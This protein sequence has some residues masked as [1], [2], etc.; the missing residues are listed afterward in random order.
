[1]RTAVFIGTNRGPVQIVRFVA[2]SGLRTGSMMVGPDGY[3]TAVQRTSDFAHFLNDMCRWGLEKCGKAPLPPHMLVMLDHDIDVGDSWQLGIM[4]AAILHAEGLFEPDLDAAEQVVLCTGSLKGQA[5]FIGRVSLIPEKLRSSAGLISELRARR[6]PPRCVWLIPRA[7]RQELLADE[8]RSPVATSCDASLHPIVHLIESVAEV[9]AALSLPALG[10]S[11]APPRGPPAGIGRRRSGWVLAAI[12]MAML[13]ALVAGLYRAGS[14]VD[15]S[16]DEGPGAELPKIAP[17]PLDGATAERPRPA[18]ASLAI[19]RQE[20]SDAADCRVANFQPGSRTMVETDLL[21]PEAGGA[22]PPL[23]GEPRLCGIVFTVAPLHGAE[24]VFAR[25]LLMANPA[26][27]VSI[28]RS[29]P[30]DGQEVLGE[31]TRTVAR[32]LPFKL[33]G[34]RLALD[35]HLVTGPTAVPSDAFSVDGPPAL[36]PAL[37][38]RGFTVSSLRQEIELP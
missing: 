28:E 27:A 11:A 23:V 29:A 34:R 12:S 30:L 33:R 22:L 17:A 15:P 35:M 3:A 5:D 24:P 20:V 14:T 38:E 18:A 4:T 10:A 37:V 6:P 32:F 8:A 7:N 19:A 9:P 31:P 2:D 1:M 25:L 21:L 13:V 36:Q 16:P 26:E